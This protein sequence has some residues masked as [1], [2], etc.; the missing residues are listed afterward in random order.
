VILLREPSDARIERFLNEQRSLP[1]SYPEVGA[2]REGAPPGYPINHGCGRLGA[3]S[4]AFER[5]AVQ[6]C[7]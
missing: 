3:G 2:S 5:A 7:P 6:M 4:E 1:F